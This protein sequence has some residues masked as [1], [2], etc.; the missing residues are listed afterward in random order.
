MGLGSLA[1]STPPGVLGLALY[2]PVTLRVVLSLGTTGLNP[3][4]R[5]E[6]TDSRGPKW[7]IPDPQIGRF[8]GPQNP[9]VLDPPE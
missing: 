6:T 7:G 5:L 3:L 2:G 8:R 1:L 4:P 9:W